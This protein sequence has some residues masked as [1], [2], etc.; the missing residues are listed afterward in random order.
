VT[1]LAFVVVLRD[2]LGNPAGHIA[3]TYHLTLKPEQYDQ[4]RKQGVVLDAGVAVDGKPVKARVVVR[5]AGTG[6]VGSL[7]LPIL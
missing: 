4:V 3:Q 1:E 7:D 5:D 6:A 2:Y